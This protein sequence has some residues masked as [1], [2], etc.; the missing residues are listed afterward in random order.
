MKKLFFVTAIILILASMTLFTGCVRVDISEKNGPITTQHYDFTDFTGVDVG[1]AFKLEVIPATSYNVTI[2][3]GENVLKRINVS[4][5]GSTLIID[6]D[7]WA[8]IWRS[9]PRVTISMPVLTYLRLSGA[10]EGSALGFKS[11][12]DFKIDLSGASSL[13]IDMETGFFIAEVSGASDVRGRLTA[14][15]SD[16][17]LSGASHMELTGSGGDIK[18]HG[19]GASSADLTYFSVINADIEFT[20]A[21]HG[22]LDVSGRLDVDLSGASSLDYLGNPT[23]GKK[24]VS[25][26]SDLEQKQQP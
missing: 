23:L 12:E 15:G 18:L 24:E 17:D 16:I 21:S 2:T 19:S 5:S 11:S 10:S 25:G 7:G 13:D 9:S 20:G 6:I 1:N 3:A 22:T 14:A 8:F 26:A 4:K